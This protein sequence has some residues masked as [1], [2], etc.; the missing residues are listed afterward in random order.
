MFSERFPSGGLQVFQTEPPRERHVP[1]AVG[2]LQAPQGLQDLAT[3][4]S[5]CGTRWGPRHSMENRNAKHPSVAGSHGNSRCHVRLTRKLLPENGTKQPR[6]QWRRCGENGLCRLHSGRRAG[7][8]RRLPPQRLLA[9]WDCLSSY[10]ET[11]KD[12]S[13]LRPFPLSPESSQG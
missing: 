5:L 9:N 13:S 1:G 12:D 11:S 10:P 8:A 6:G 3:I 2:F 4:T 7:L